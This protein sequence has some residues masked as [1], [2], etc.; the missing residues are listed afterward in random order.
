MM[1]SVLGVSA[2]ARNTTWAPASASCRP[3]WPTVLAASGTGSGWWRT[4]VAVTRNGASR[5]SRL[6]VIPPPPRIV[7]GWSY[8]LV[9]A[10]LPQE[11]AVIRWRSRRRPARASSERVLGHR[12][13]VGALGRGPGPARVEDPGRGQPLDAGVRKLHPARGTRRGQRGA[14]PVDVGRVE[15]DQRVGAGVDVGG[16]AAAVADRLLGE[17]TAVRADGH[18]G[19]CHAQHPSAPHDA[20]RPSSCRGGT[21][22]ATA[23]R[24][25]VPRAASAATARSGGPG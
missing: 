5:P 14:Q 8:R 24:C 1:R 11:R 18:Q 7:T 10:G 21:R 16:L 25:R 20:V 17:V 3:A 9:P 4:T 19:R 2:R 22:C 12:L 15:P 23:L 13:G 6:A